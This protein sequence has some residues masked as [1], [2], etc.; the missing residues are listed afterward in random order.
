[1]SEFDV[2]KSIMNLGVEANILIMKCLQAEE[3]Q[4]KS[5]EA[6]KEELSPDIGTIVDILNK[7]DG[8]KNL[9]ILCTLVSTLTGHILAKLDIKQEATNGHDRPENLH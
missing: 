9:L 2:I 4:K 3:E 1:M 8:N 7:Y 6:L 5:L